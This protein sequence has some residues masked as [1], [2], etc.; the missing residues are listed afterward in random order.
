VRLLVDNAVSPRVAEGLRALGHDAVH[1]RDVDLQ[2]ATDEVIFRYAA[3]ENRIVISEDS[4]F[5][6]LL[7]LRGDVGPSVIL[8]RH[9]PDRRSE[10]LLAVLA[11]NLGAI[12]RALEAGAIVTLEPERIRIRR[13]PIEPR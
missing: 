12:G 7:A 2:A 5:G 6:T 3:E 4:D 8:F 1:V 13:L 9:M 11:A 10:A